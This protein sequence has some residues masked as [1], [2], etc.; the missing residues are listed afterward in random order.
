MRSILRLAMVS[1]VDR[2]WLDP[3]DSDLLVLDTFGEVGFWCT[4]AS[5]GMP[6]LAYTG[7]PCGV[8]EAVEHSGSDES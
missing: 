1:R 6:D 2:S 5:G 7:Y 3:V 8:S 4:G